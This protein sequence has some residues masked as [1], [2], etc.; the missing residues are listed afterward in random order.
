MNHM[1]MIF[2]TSSI[3]MRWPAVVTLILKSLAFITELQQAL[4]RFDCLF[5]KR[6]WG[7]RTVED[8][9]RNATPN[10]TQMID[11]FEDEA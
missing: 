2:I 6:E 1:I 10:H 11:I 8:F 3:N 9:N 5:D 4:V 7:G